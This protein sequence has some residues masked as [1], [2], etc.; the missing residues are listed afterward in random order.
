MV[1]FLFS[2]LTITEAKQYAGLSRAEPGRWISLARPGVAPPLVTL[3]RPTT[4]TGSNTF[5]SPTIRKLDVLTVRPT[6]GDFTFA[7]N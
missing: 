1:T 3:S 2:V 4:E 6:Q 7:R 5:A